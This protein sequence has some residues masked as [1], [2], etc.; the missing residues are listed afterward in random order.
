[1]ALENPVVWTSL[2]QSNLCWTPNWTWGLVQEN[3][4]TLNWTFPPLSRTLRFGSKDFW[5]STTWSQCQVMARSIGLWDQSASKAWN[6]G[7]GGLISWSISN[8]MQ[9]SHESEERTGWQSSK[10]QS[11]DRSQWTQAG[12]GST[13]SATAKMPTVRVVL[14]NA[15]HQD[16]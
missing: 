4:Q 8:T 16:W 14:A 15:A 3:F 1:M 2:N 7:C 5:Q 10:L 6:L 11:A 9:R 13:F 12:W